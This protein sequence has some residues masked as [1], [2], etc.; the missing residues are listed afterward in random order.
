MDRF[1]VRDQV[2]LEEDLTRIV[3]VIEKH[4]EQKA[5]AKKRLRLRLPT[6]KRTSD[7]GSSP[8]RGSWMRSRATTTH[9]ATSGS[10]R[11]NF[12]CT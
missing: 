9:S 12:S 1:D 7:G 2:Q 5:T 8:I 4:K 3:E 6:I 10:G 11:T